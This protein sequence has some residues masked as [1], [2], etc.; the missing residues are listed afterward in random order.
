MLLIRKVRLCSADDAAVAGREPGRDGVGAAAH[1]VSLPFTHAERAG[2]LL[3]LLELAARAV[4]AVERKLGRPVLV[5]VVNP[6]R[7]P[8]ARADAAHAGTLGAAEDADVPARSAIGVHG[9]I[10]ATR[11]SR[12]YWPNGETCRP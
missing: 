11:R 10:I 1:P 8:A 6:V 7:L 9:T 3:S 5:R 12:Y 2:R 4:G